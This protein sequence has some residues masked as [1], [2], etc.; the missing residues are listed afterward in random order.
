MHAMQQTNAAT[1]CNHQARL[2]TTDFY[3]FL[4]LALTMASYSQTCS[5]TKP[6]AS[7]L[8]ET[9]MPRILAQRSRRSLWNTTLLDIEQISSYYKNNNYKGSDVTKK[10]I[11]TTTPRLRYY[12]CSMLAAE[13][14]LAAEIF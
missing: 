11:S 8:K 13:Q 4:P 9:G 12:T 2:Y 3:R 6:V 14:L 7:R 5:D 10:H 1:K